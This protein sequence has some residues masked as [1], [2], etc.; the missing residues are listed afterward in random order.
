MQRIA[1]KV[2]A[3]TSLCQIG[4]VNDGLATRVLKII[5]ALVNC[6]VV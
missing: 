2:F 5:D 1:T 3:S 4:L 6:S